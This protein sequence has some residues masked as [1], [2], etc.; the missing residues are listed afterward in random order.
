MSSPKISLQMNIPLM[1][2]APA[3]ILA[4]LD[5]QGEQRAYRA[6]DRMEKGV[7][8]VAFILF[9]LGLVLVVIK[10]AVDKA[11]TWAINKAN[12][13]A[14]ID[15]E[16]VKC[17]EKAKLR[18][19]ECEAEAKL[20]DTNNQSDVRKHREEKIID[21]DYEKE[22]ARIKLADGFTPDSNDNGSDNSPNDKLWLDDY[23]KKHPM[24]QLPSF[25]KFILGCPEGYEIAVLLNMLSMLGAMC[26]SRVRAKY[27]DGVAK[28]PNLQV[29]IEGISGGGK[30]LFKR[31]YD[32]Y[33]GRIKE[34]DAEKEKS[35][36][37]S[38][39]EKEKTSEQKII[40]TKGID[41]ST[42][43]LCELL[44]DNQ[45][46]HLYIQESEII[47]VV[48]LQKQR[49]GIPASYFL[50]AFDN[51][52]VIRTTKNGETR[53]KL[54]LNYTFTGTA[55]GVERFIKGKV[56][57]GTAGRICWGV[58]PMDMACISQ[59]TPELPEDELIENYRDQIDLWRGKY[60]FTTDEE[61]N[62]IAVP[63]QM[64][65]LSYVNEALSRWLSKQEKKN[66]P[67]RN[68]VARR[69]GEMA[70]HCAIILHMLWGEPKEGNEDR[71]KVV[72]LTLYLADYLIE[73]YLKKFS[74]E[75][76]ESIERNRNA[77][78][79]QTTSSSSSKPVFT[80]ELCA[81][82]IMKQKAGS[83]WLEIAR[84]LYTTEDAVK[85]QIKR[86][87]KRLNDK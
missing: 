34:S 77:E 62:D 61:G 47:R 87:K 76:K 13:S 66:E 53:F 2:Y 7:I 81:E 56:A 40:S 12:N 42:A 11:G 44:D 54:Y 18:E 57:D 1:N 10:I 8:N 24:P 85:A 39:A 43:A 37:D 50:P 6:M 82:L 41:T 46:V 23:R 36:K 20:H 84:D 79:V 29:I 30:S 51:D 55:E 15:L 4:N 33:F 17:E 21:L 26:F 83:T 63:E 60:C 25:L 65:D 19:R 16:R 73:R 80:D 70:F 31:I 35:S 27:L 52:D 45:G 49:K 58:I 67:E 69:F 3:A 48:E 32:L 14:K 71:D 5:S 78:S 68:A 22:K 9:M 28:A 59:E 74:D 75:L 72:K 38:D 64:I 86:Y